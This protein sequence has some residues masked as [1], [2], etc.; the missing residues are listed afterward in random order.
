MKTTK[1]EKQKIARERIKILFQ[2][3]KDIFPKNPKR[4]NRYIELA[5][6]V[7]MKT[8]LRLTKPQK[9]KFCSHCYQYLQTGTNA[10][11]RTRDKKLIIYCQTCKKY[12]RIPLSPKIK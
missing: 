1:Q 11:I 9:R 7:A 12:T 4:A 6:K 8:N 5:R 10:R 3:A 2:Q